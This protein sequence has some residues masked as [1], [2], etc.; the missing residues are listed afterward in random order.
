MKKSL[1]YLVAIATIFGLLPVVNLNFASAQSCDPDSL[2][3]VRY[4]QRGS[5]VKALQECLIELGYNIPS[6]ATGYYGNQTAAA[7]LEFYRDANIQQGVALRGRSFG[8]LGISALRQLVASTEEETEDNTQTQTQTQTQNGGAQQNFN[9]MLAAVLE[10]LRQLGVLPST[11]T[12][13]QQ[14]QQTGEEG[15]LTVERDPSVVGVTVR[16]GET[17]NIFGLRFRADNAPVAVKSIYLRWTGSGAA[18]FRIFTNLSLV[19]A[20]GN[21]LY[22][23]PVNSQ[24]FRQDNTTLEYYLP[25]TGLNINVPVGQNTSVFVR[26]TVVSTLPSNYSGV[27]FEVRTNDVRAVDGAGIDRY[28]PQS[29]IDSNFTLQASLAQNAK[30][31]VSRNPNTPVEGYILGNPSSGEANNVTLLTFDVEAKDDNLRLT[32]INVAL[33]NTSKVR[34]VKL[35]AGE[36]SLT[37]EAASGTVVLNVSNNNFYIN[38][39]QRVTFRI[40][41]DL[42][43]GATNS[44]AVVTTTVTGIRGLNSL[45]DTVIV[46]GLNIT[47]EPLYFRTLGPEIS[48]FT[49]TTNYQ[50]PANNASSSYSATIRFNV[51]PRG[52]TIY[53]G[54]TTLAAITSTFGAIELERSDGATSTP[55]GGVSVR[56]YQGSNDV[57][58]NLTLSSNGLFTLSENQTYTFEISPAQNGAPSG[59]T[60]LYRW[61]V[62]NLKWD[63]DGSNPIETMTWTSRYIYTNYQNIQ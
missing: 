28:G 48:G 53:M 29:K 37:S 16:E 63:T 34:N 52:G 58:N 61:V 14:Q 7:V 6:G 26:A 15:L 4:G 49:A 8:P 51:T 5:A 22:S 42:Y 19:D 10:M 59:V 54:T 45:G 23:T 38:R 12:Q 56:V 36:Q 3:P 32:Q 31:V 21:V 40:V 11:S 9:E 39:D 27:K 41:A 57:T 1:I 13:Q 47:S 24:T 50:P 33:N 20:N 17:A 43:N 55:N 30:F 60:G 2:R 25:I 62:R 46:P 35:F 44:E 18:P